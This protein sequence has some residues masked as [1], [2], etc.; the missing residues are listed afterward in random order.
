MDGRLLEWVAFTS[1]EDPW[2]RFTKHITAFQVRVIGTITLSTGHL[3]EATGLFNESSV[4]TDW[5]KIGL[6]ESL[7]FTT[8]LL[9]VAGWPLR[10]LILLFSWLLIC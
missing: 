2:P 6:F 1:F 8:L 3:K 4:N 7:H 9:Y 10:F 5:P